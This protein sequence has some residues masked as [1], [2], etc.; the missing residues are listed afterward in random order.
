[1]RKVHLKEIRT[2][3]VRHPNGSVLEYSVERFSAL[4]CTWYNIRSAYGIVGRV[5]EYPTLGIRA[6]LAVHSAV[7]GLRFRGL[8][9][10][11]KTSKSAFTAL[12]TAARL[13][14][15]STCK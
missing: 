12:M 11:W 10:R 1:M 2:A 8:P 6:D 14:D 7:Q 5:T 3:H 4:G 9:G 13:F 15:G